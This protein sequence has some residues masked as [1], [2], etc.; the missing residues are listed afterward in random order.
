[1]ANDFGSEADGALSA[2]GTDD[3]FAGDANVPRETP[4][5]RKEGGSREAKDRRAP[6]AGDFAGAG[7]AAVF[8]EGSAGAETA[9]AESAANGAW[10][11]GPKESDETSAPLTD[12]GCG[13]EPMETGA[14][15]GA[16]CAPLV[17]GVAGGGVRTVVGTDAPGALSC[18]PGAS[19]GIETV[20]AGAAAIGAEVCAAVSLSAVGAALEPKICVASQP[21]AV[22]V[23]LATEL[24]AAVPL[25][26]AEAALQPN[27]C[28]VSLRLAVVVTA[29]P[30]ICPVVLLPASVT[31]LATETSGA[32]SLGPATVIRPERCESGGCVAVVAAPGAANSIPEPAEA[33]ASFGWSAVPGESGETIARERGAVGGGTTGAGKITG[34]AGVGDSAESDAVGLALADGP[35]DEVPPRGFPPWAAAG[36]LFAS[37]ACSTSEKVATALRGVLPAPGCAAVFPRSDVPVSTLAVGIVC[38]TSTMDSICPAHRKASRGPKR[39]GESRLCGPRKCHKNRGLKKRLKFF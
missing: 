35:S 4:A 8:P 19:A 6:A 12:A 5:A 15:A 21:P 10:L 33:G 31:K 30:E 28:A 14:A 23:K 22:A 17:A 34:T 20:T 7:S 37:E 2:A 18:R 24:C 29:G 11:A 26:S 1:V 25:P 16:A 13:A 39:N 27:V 36:A 9:K 38:D 3:A 32:A